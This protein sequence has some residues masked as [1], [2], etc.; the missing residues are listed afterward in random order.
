MKAF[1]WEKRRDHVSFWERFSG[2]NVEERGSGKLEARRPILR[3]L[4][5]FRRDDGV[6]D[7]V[8]AEGVEKGR[9]LPTLSFAPP[10]R[11]RQPSP[12]ASL[13]PMHTP[14]VLYHDLL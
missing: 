7:E 14:V 5:K 13:N 2:C 10:S 9:L 11:Y 8:I 12:I 3:Q 4:Q 1:K 6:L